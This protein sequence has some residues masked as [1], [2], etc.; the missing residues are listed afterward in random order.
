MKTIREWFDEL[1]NE[2]K[3][4]AMNNANP[5][6]INAKAKSLTHALSGSFVWQTTPEGGD[7]WIAVAFYDG[8]NNT[9]LPPIP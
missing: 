7:F 4:L 8:I 3:I 9:K 1:P 2:Y 6:T 5:R